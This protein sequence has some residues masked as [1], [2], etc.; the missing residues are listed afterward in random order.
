MCPLFQN[1]KICLK[2]L[3]KKYSQIWIQKYIV[4]EKM[5]FETD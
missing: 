1:Q 4:L 3:V 5:T 2:I